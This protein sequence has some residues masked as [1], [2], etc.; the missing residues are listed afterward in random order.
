[1]PASTALV[2]TDRPSRYMKQLVSHFGRKLE[3][4]IDGDHAELTFPGSGTARFD[5]SAPGTLAMTI[6]TA[7]VEQLDRLKDVVARHLTRF[8]TQDELRVTWS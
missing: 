4:S 2:A 7:D 6:E 1:M 5:A 8:A 3:H